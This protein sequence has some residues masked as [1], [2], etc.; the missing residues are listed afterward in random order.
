M[1]PFLDGLLAVK[2][3]FGEYSALFQQKEALLQE[4]RKSR[5][6]LSNRLD[7]AKGD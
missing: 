4:N 5:L 6:N 1:Q 3:K 2:D 7:Q